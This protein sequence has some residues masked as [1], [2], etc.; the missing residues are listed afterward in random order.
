MLFLYSRTYQSHFDAFSVRSLGIRRSGVRIRL[1]AGNVEAKAMMAASAPLRQ[2]PVSTAKATTAL[3]PNHAP[4]GY[5]NKEIQRVKTE[6]C[7]SYGDAMRL[8]TS[9]SSSSS[10]A[11]CSYASAVK[12][13]SKKVTMNF[14]CQTPAFWIGKQPSLLE[15]SKLNPVQTVSKGSGTCETRPP[16]S[17]SHHKSSPSAASGKISNQK[18]QSNIKDAKKKTINNNNN[19]KDPKD[20]E[21][22]TKYHTLASDVDEEMD[23]THSPR[24]ARS[25]SRSRS[26][27]KNISPIKHH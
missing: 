17:V 27:S 9:A 20:I 1:P 5:R 24:P 23:T 7:L 3:R 25:K 10:P 15:A 21:S 8:V 11:A 19:N 22:L 16:T 18:T 6:K 13:V 12:T 4:F 14:E 2:L 26:R